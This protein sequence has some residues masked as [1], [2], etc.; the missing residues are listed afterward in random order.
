MITDAS[1]LIGL[2]FLNRDS[3][4]EYQDFIIEEKEPELL[5]DWFGYELAKDIMSETPSTEAQALIDGFEYTD[6]S[7]DL[8][9]LTGLEKSLVYFMY[10]Y[11]ARDQRSITTSLGEKEAL[12]ENA[13]VYDPAPKLVQNY[14]TGVKYVNQMIYYLRHEGPNDYLTFDFKGYLETI[15]RFGI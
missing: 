4:E 15:N 2:S 11:I 8:Q 12:A 9:K 14:N 6:S 3:L 1:K 10:F 5:I 13:A 7:G